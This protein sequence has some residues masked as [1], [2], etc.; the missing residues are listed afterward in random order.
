M[1]VVTSNISD[2]QAQSVGMHQKVRNLVLLLLA[3]LVLSVVVLR[4]RMKSEQC[5]R[6]PDKSELASEFAVV[7]LLLAP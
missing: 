2:T 5:H 4:S 1:V 7:A 6:Y 3:G